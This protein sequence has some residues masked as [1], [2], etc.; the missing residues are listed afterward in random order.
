M[1]LDQYRRPWRE[2]GMV[3]RREFIQPAANNPSEMVIEEDL[4]LDVRAA[5]RAIRP[6][7][8][9]RNVEG[10]VPEIGPVA[11]RVPRGD[12]ADVARL[13][14]E[15]ACVEVERERLPIDAAREQIGR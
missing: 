3:N 14:V 15:R 7:W 2:H 13:E 9:N 4:V 8:R 12:R 10:V 6:C 1:R 11:H 5:F